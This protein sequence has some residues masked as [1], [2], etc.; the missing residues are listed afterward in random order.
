[1]RGRGGLVRGAVELV[2]Q[3]EQRAVHAGRALVLAGRGQRERQARGGRDDRHARRQGVHRARAVAEEGADAVGPRDARR[4]R[5][6]V[7]AADGARDGGVHGAFQGRQQWQQEGEQH[8]RERKQHA[9]GDEAAAAARAPVVPSVARVAGRA[10][11]GL[12]RVAGQAHRAKGAGV[13]GRAVV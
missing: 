12:Q 13:A 9:A 11:A 3:L 5:A 4:Q 1:V 10:H 6:A 2:A 8:E 7:G